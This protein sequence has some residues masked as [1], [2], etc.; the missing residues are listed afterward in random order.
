MMS[1][2]RQATQLISDMLREGFLKSETPYGLLSF[3]IPSRAL[4]FYVP[5]L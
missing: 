2:E 4:R 3:E 5:L 1:R